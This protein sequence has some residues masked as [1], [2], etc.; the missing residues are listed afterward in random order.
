MAQC[1]RGLR[2]GMQT[3][4]PEQQR[5]GARQRCLR[6]HTSVRRSVD[7]LMEPLAAPRGRGFGL[8][9]NGRGA[10]VAGAVVAVQ[11]K[12]AWQV[13]QSCVVTRCWICLPVA[14]MPL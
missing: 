9:I 13:P 10:A 1:R 4:E 8:E 6:E 3:D 7:H 14:M 2:V 11:F 12:V 5:D